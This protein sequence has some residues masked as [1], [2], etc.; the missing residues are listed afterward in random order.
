MAISKIKRIT[1]LPKTQKQYVYD[2][3]VNRRTPYFFANNILV[4]NT[5]SVYF[6]IT[7]AMEANSHLKELYQDFEVTKESIVQLYDVVADQV[8]D[9]FN[10]FLT[11]NFNV[12]PE[13]AVI[14]AGRELVGIKALFIKKKRYAV[15]IYDLEG[16]RTDV[17]GP[18]KI[19]AMGL[20]LKRSDT[21]KPVQKFLEDLL[22]QVLTGATEETIIQ[23]IREFKEDFRTWPAWEKGTPKRVNN[24]SDYLMRLERSKSFEEY[25][26]L[27]KLLIKAK[28]DREREAI[29]KDIEKLKKITIPGHVMASINYNKLRKLKHDNYCM[30]IQDGGKIIVCKLKPNMFNMNSVAYPIDENN[31]PDWFRDLPFDHEEM[32][33]AIVD[34]KVANLLSVL[35]W[36]LNRAKHN[37]TFDDLFTL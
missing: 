20:D 25:N 3:G 5:D 36:D 18:G 17:D 29:R 6:S 9:S 2:I 16:K 13:F 21:P 26:E 14:A 12:N 4:H 35:G 7:S 8:N 10:D 22:T 27:Q 15:L 33:A 34:K 1:K 31:L 19:K 32:E 37:T 28:T 23:A 24:L 11:E 30:P